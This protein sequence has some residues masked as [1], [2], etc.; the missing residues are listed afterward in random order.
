M[1]VLYKAALSLI[2]NSTTDTNTIQEL[3]YTGSIE[4]CSSIHPP[5]MHMASKRAAR[6]D[7]RQHQPDHLVDLE[8]EALMGQNSSDNDEQPV[9]SSIFTGQVKYLLVV[10]LALLYFL[11]PLP[12]VFSAGSYLSAS[13][14]S[15]LSSLLDFSFSSSSSSTPC[16]SYGHGRPSPYFNSDDPSSH[17]R[18][19][20][21][22]FGSE[23]IISS[24]AAL[25]AKAR[26]SLHAGPR[27]ETYN[28]KI[29][30]AFLKVPN[31]ES[32]IAASRR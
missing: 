13:S 5:H 23:K 28:H 30:Q 4:Y 26:P 24:G 15:A 12:A 10:S 7:D 18:G 2:L 29:E 9:N 17:A 8:K 32:C 27:D 11:L 25:F 3:L 20:R 31:N 21:A 6:E 19:Y 14:S 16:H 1:A 22:I